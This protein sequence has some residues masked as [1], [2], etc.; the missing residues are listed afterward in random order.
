MNI[1]KRMKTSGS[2]PKALDEFEEWIQ[3]IL[4]DK[5]DNACKENS[6]IYHD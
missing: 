5:S 3:E 4:D 1:W 6:F 2:A